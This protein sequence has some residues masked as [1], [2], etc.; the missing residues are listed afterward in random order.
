MLYGEKMREYKKVNTKKLVVSKLVC[1][2]CGLEYNTEERD[3]EEWQ[4]KTIFPFKVHFGYSTK[5]DLENWEFDLCEKC[6]EEIV[7]AFKVAPTIESYD[8]WH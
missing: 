2:R 7:S 6:I 3:F 1:N 5:H 8:P 4:W